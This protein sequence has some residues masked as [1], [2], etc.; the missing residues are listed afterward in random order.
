MNARDLRILS[1]ALE[2]ASTKRFGDLR[3]FRLT[4]IGVRSDGAM[5]AASNGAVMET[6][7]LHR[8]SFPKAHAEARLSRKLDVGSV[9][10]VARASKSGKAAMAKPCPSCKAFLKSRGCKRVVYT[11]FEGVGEEIL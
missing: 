3:S 11:T 9:V 6:G 1:L 7:R 10:Y 4:A 8:C 2:M 5:V